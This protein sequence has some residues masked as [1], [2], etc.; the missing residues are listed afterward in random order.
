MPFLTVF[1]VISDFLLFATAALIFSITILCLLL[2]IR[3]EDRYL[4]SFLG[5]LI[6]LTLQIG[7][8]TIATY[9]SR[10]GKVHPNSDSAYSVFFL[11]GTFLSIFCSAAVLFF[12]SRYLIDLLPI[13]AKDKILGN[14]IVNVISLL[15][16]FSCL[17]AAFFINRGNWA[18]AMDLAM[19]DLF[20]AASGILTAH[21]ITSLFF[22][23][24]A[25]SRELEN[26]LR[27]IA[28]TFLPLVLFVTLDMIF[29][30]NNSFK[31]T[32]ITYSVFC[33]SL[34]LFISR[35]YFRNYEPAPESIQPN[36]V[37]LK[38]FGFSD[39]ESQ[40][41]RLL[42]QGKTNFEIAQEL[43]IS[44]NTVK[45]HIKNIYSKLKISNRVQ[46]IQNLRGESFPPISGLSPPGITR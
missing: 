3:A 8:Y 19:K 1:A 13:K 26:L 39:R 15:F 41:T 24:K 11:F 4:H 45:T 30:R 2:R 27:S 28:V 31:L 23:K 33:V 29:L 22:L 34:Y 21:G 18:A 14:R 17:Y 16:L 10:V 9:L 35:H 5:I 12:L 25:E 38:K 20:L 32:F 40:I 42:I 6:P 36:P 44:V 46:L 7:L 37:L 43:F